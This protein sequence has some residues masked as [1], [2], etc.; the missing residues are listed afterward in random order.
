MAPHLS[1]ALEGRESL[2]QYH[3]EIGIIY[4]IC[5]LPRS[6]VVERHVHGIAAFPSFG[7]TRTST[8]VVD[9]AFEVL[10]CF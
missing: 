7:R 5:R 2:A 4:V 9:I 6:S 10:D 1:G 8:A 3:G